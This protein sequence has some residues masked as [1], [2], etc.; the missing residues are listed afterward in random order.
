MYDL[1]YLAIGSLGF[2]IILMSLMQ[3]VYYIIAFFCKDRNRIY[4]IIKLHRI[5]LL[6]MI[7]LLLIG[8]AI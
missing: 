2:L 4:R 7:V 1:R 5:A 6:V 8:A 3:V